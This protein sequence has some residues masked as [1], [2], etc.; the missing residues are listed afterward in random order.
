[1]PRLKETKKNT[2]PRELILPIRQP[3]DP[4]SNRLAYSFAKTIRAELGISLDDMSQFF[5]SSFEG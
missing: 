1:M 5:E 2:L 4:L 3:V